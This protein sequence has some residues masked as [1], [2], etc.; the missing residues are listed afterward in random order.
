M[1]L[2][3]KKNTPGWLIVAFDI[4][5]VIV[6]II[7]AYLLRFNFEIPGYEIEPM[8]L[9][10]TYMALVRFISFI[11]G[12][13]YSGF[14]RFTS[15]QDVVRLFIVMLSGSIIFCITN[16]VT[17]YLIGGFFFIPFSIIIIEFLAS[18][19]GISALRIIVKVTYLEMT[20]HSAH[21]TNV[22][23]FGAGEAGLL[24]KKVLERDAGSRIKVVAFLDDDKQKQ[25]KTIE[26]ID[27]YKTE[28]LSSIIDKKD[29]RQIIISVPD[30]KPSKKR[31]II[32]TSLE[33][34]V[35][36]LHVPPIVKWIKGELSLKQ[37]KQIKIEDLLERE[38]IRLE[39]EKTA[40]DLQGKTVMITGAAGSIGSELVRQ[41]SEFSPQ[42]ILAVDQAETPLFHLELECR[43]NHPNLNYVFIVADI[44]N[45]QRIKNIFS[46]SKP[47]IIFHS[48]AYKHVPVM[49]LNACEAI[50]TNV[51][52]TRILADM[53]LNY[54]TSKFIMISTD[55]AVN[56]TNI[57][58]ASKRIAEMYTQALNQKNRTRFITTRFGNVL[59]S[60]GSVV[61]LFRQQIEKGGPVTLTH[62]DIQRY[63]MTISEACQLVLDAGAMGKGGE[64]FVFDMGTP[65]K[66]M[67]MARKMIMLYGLEPDKDIKIEIAGLRPGE[68]LF[69]ELL[70][71][72]ENTIPTHHPQILK[73]KVFEI[74][75]ED[76]TPEISELL[77]ILKNKGDTDLVKKM[78]EIVPEFI[79]KNSVYEQLD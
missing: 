66:I 77:K 72:K 20:N 21:K 69:E 52:G 79:S 55:K 18:S 26:G 36:V 11:I 58:G 48:A 5:I 9:I 61:H 59:G 63:F 76:I 29:A 71:D 73:A 57:M 14:L 34:N 75:L 7:I 6:A 70:S 12:K 15:T 64:I 31:F 27:I 10:I 25:G 78:K 38:V 54:G 39:A 74:A 1:N 65:V 2:L 17:F 62:P 53:A 41:I 23:I 40:K 16:L 37:F 30:L 24:T 13:T 56:P 68:K 43:E 33:K 4:L 51:S 42:K 49:E 19:M 44:C 67:D 46:D 50:N 3:S 8:P 60:S 28:L 47:D 32:E 35:R 45:H 22:I